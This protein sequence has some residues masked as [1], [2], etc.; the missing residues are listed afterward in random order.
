MLSKRY[1][2]EVRAYA[3]CGMISATV[4]GA[5]YGLH[6]D[7]GSGLCSLLHPADAAAEAG[8]RS[9]RVVQQLRN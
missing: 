5:S 9:A 6:R 7:G 8:C 4:L 2:R 1:R 3:V